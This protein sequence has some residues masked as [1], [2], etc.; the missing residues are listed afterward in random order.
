MQVK[1]L[2]LLRKYIYLHMTGMIRYAHLRPVNSWSL[3]PQVTVGTEIEAWNALRLSI[4]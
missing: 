1:I 4:R 2:K 3:A